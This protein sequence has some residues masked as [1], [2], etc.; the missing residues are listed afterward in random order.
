MSVGSHSLNLGLLDQEASM[1]NIDRLMEA[2]VMEAR[3]LGMSK[4]KKLFSDELSNLALQRTGRKYKKDAWQDIAPWFGFSLTLSQPRS[5]GW[6]MDDFKKFFLEGHPNGYAL[7]KQ[8][9]LVINQVQRMVGK[10]NCS[11]CS[12]TLVLLVVAHVDPRMADYRPNWHMWVSFEIRGRL[13]HDRND[14]FLGGKFREEWQAIM[15]IVRADFLA[16]QA[17]TMHEPLL[18]EARNALTN[19]RAEWDNEK[20]ELVREKEALKEELNKAKEMAVEA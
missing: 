7:D 8:V 9:R 3:E 13:G 4:R 14:K 10:A 11:F 15:R 5:E 17:T 1:Q 2:L 12:I 19:T 18:L 16:K 6:L 20:G